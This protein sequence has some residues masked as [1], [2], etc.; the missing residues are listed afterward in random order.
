MARRE[1]EKKKKEYGF[2]VYGH[3]TEIF[4]YGSDGRTTNDCKCNRASQ[5]RNNSLLCCHAVLHCLDRAEVIFQPVP[6]RMRLLN[7][8]T[9]NKRIM[10]TRMRAGRTNSYP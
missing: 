8:R 1:R 10:Q 2:L 7:I 4:C 9:K 5:R 6:I 3:D